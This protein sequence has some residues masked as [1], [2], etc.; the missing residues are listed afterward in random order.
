[1]SRRHRFREFFSHFAPWLVIAYFGLVVVG[2]LGFYLNTQAVKKDTLEQ[3]AVQRCLTAR[4]Y[5]ERQKAF[6]QLVLTQEQLDQ[7][8]PLH[9]PTIAQCKSHR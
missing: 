4:K 9:V 8:P 2:T 1:M 7:L 6:E 3:A 5:L